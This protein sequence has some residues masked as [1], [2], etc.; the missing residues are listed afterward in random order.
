MNIIINH[1]QTGFL[2]N[3]FIAENGMTLNIWIEQARIQQ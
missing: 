3:R 1:Y 2:G